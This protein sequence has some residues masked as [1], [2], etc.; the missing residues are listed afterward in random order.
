LEDG[1]VILS[2][3]VTGSGL[4]YLWS[5]GQY[6]DNPNIKNP[7]FTPGQDQLYRLTVRG[8]GGCE[9][10]DEVFIKV[11]KSPVVPNAFSPNG[12]G[13]NDTWNIQYLDSYPGCTVELFDRHGHSLFTSYG[14][15]K[16]WDGKL[17]GKDLPVGVYYYIINPK[18][19]KKPFSGMLTLLR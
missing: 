12:D 9:A 2:P 1:Y 10:S 4:S 18:N 17:N 16:P 6:L 13:I 3:V 14:Y 8:T 15:T 19:G 5:P 11:L 7:R